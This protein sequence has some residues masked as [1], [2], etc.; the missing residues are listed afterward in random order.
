MLL[1]SLKI[2]DML[3]FRCLTSSEMMADLVALAVYTFTPDEGCDEL[4]IGIRR[5]DIYDICR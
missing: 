5:W 3:S 1:I 2:M 4:L